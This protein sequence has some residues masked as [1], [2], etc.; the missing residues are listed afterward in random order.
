MKLLAQNLEKIAD[1]WEKK[2]YYSGSYTVGGEKVWVKYP[3]RNAAATM[4]VAQTGKDEFT[5][6][7][8]KRNDVLSSLVIA[9]AKQ[10]FTIPKEFVRVLSEMARKYDIL[11]YYRSFT[12]SEFIP[13][14]LNKEG[15]N[16]S[17]LYTWFPDLKEKEVEHHK[18]M[19]NFTVITGDSVSEKEVENVE[20]LIQTG[21]QLLSDFGLGE[22]LYGKIYI[23]AS[24][25][26]VLANY[27]SSDDTIRISN[28]SRRSETATKTFIHE[29]GHRLYAKKLTTN[30]KVAIAKKFA[31]EVQYIS[32]LPKIGDEFQDVH[33]VKYKVITIKPGSL[34]STKTYYVMTRDDKPGSMFRVDSKYFVGMKRTK[35]EPH[36]SSAWVPSNYSKKNEQEWFCEI[37]AWGLVDRNSLWLDFVRSLL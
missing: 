18:Q 14:M 16:A 15:I 22:I 27:T 10:H 37:L 28:R 33:G 1:L 20:D 26:R 30:A 35:G 17:T 36:D 7:S 29:L 25:G 31:D 21:S 2:S 24:M 4:F 3:T 32:L 11:K 23:L 34:Y 5:V 6:L 12:A 9:G 13:H 19:G 8:V